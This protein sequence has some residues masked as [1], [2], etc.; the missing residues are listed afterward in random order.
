LTYADAIVPV[1]FDYPHAQMIEG[2]LDPI[3]AYLK[4]LPPTS[5]GYA[6][7]VFDPAR[8]VEATSIRR[9]FFRQP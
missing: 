3:A 6:P 4:T 9:F 1:A 7:N 8:G 5:G 2:M